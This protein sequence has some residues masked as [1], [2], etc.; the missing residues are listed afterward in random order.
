[1]GLTQFPPPRIAALDIDY[2]DASLGDV[3]ISGTVT[4]VAP[5]FYRNLIVPLGATLVANGHPIYA[6]ESITIGGVIHADGAVGGICAGGQGGGYVALFTRVLVNS[7]TVRA[8]GGNGGAYS[9]TPNNGGNGGGT[10]D[11]GGGGGGAGYGVSGGVGRTRGG[12]GST[13]GNYIIHGGGG[14]G[15]GGAGGTSR[16]NI[17]PNAGGG[18]GGQAFRQNSRV[19]AEYWASESSESGPWTSARCHLAGGAGGAGG[20]YYASQTLHGSGGGGGATWGKGGSWNSPAGSFPEVWARLGYLPDFNYPFALF[21]GGGGGAGSQS[22]N[23]A[24]GGGGGGLIVTVTR[25]R[26]GAGVYQ[27]DGGAAGSAPS[28]S[29]AF[30]AEAGKPGFVVHYTDGE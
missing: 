16:D 19:G 8:N 26:S 3:E 1:M 29:A 27:V 20:S 25:S 13:N 17:T 12:T 24:G 5:A 9:L 7:G 28:G 23:Q 10:V 4:L 11:N 2:G 22:Q 18:S 21:G 30:L 14:G 15:A 6:T